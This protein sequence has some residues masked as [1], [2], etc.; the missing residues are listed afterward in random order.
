MRL[1]AALSIC[2]LFAMGCDR[3]SD[4]SEG[5]RPVEF[6]A[7]ATDQTIS[8]GESVT[9]I[10]SS[11][12]VSSRLWTITKDTL[13]TTETS[14]QKS[15]TVTYDAPSP[16][17][18]DLGNYFAYE[19]NLQVTFEDG[20]T[21]DNS[22]G[23]TVYP[24][25]GL[26]FETNLD[27]AIVGST[28][29][30][31]SLST[32]LE[33]QFEDSQ[34]LDTFEWEFPGGSPSSSTE[35]NPSVI[36]NTPGTYPVIITARR[37]APEDDATLTR[38]GAITIVNELA[39]VPDFT[40]DPTE[41]SADQSVTFTDASTGGA[42]TYNWTFPG[43]TPETST[44]KNPVVTYSGGGFFDVT[45]EVTRNAD[46]TT[47][48]TTKEDFIVVDSPFCNTPENLVGC[49]NNDGEGENLV[50]WTAT[51]NPEDDPSSTE[52]SR[53]DNLSISTD[54]AFAGEASI[55]YSYSEPG[56]PGFTDVFIDYN[57]KLV[58]VTEAG[59][60]M[61]SMQHFGAVIGGTEYV[62]LFG[63]VN[64]STGMYSNS[65]VGRFN[66]DEWVNT[67]LSFDLEPGQYFV[68]VQL[69]NPGFNPTQSIDLYMDEISVVRN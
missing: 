61:V 7:T 2:I 6:K 53:K 33:S 9:F 20:T 24:R 59:N 27:T 49:G 25:I 12:N 57:G 60:Y 45:L 38:T 52:G 8:V 68:R 44:K 34:E 40:A 11:L 50:D 17:N 39:L 16:P 46:G 19:A 18:E 43:G 1:G 15:F 41:I 3:E 58:D 14:D 10:D 4:V 35:E 5:I 48:S 32:A 63:L 55:L 56:A 26:D 47:E 64:S 13:G 30:F 29:Q 37:E 21:Q 69:F 54:Q 62:F 23:V 22:F 51:L 28:I 31:T 36:Y 42:D 66:A 65:F 67:S